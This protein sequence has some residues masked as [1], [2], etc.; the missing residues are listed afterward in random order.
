MTDLHALLGKAIPDP[1]RLRW[2]NGGAQLSLAIHCIFA[3]AKFR[4]LDNAGKRQRNPWLPPPE[5]ESRL[6]TEW[7][8]QY[9]RDD[10]A[11]GF[12]LHCSLHAATGRMF[13]HASEVLRDG[14]LVAHN[15]QVL[16]LQLQKYTVAGP[17]VD[18]SW[19]DIV[20]NESALVD[21]VRQYLIHPL[22]DQAT[23]APQDSSLPE[24]TS[25]GVSS[26]TGTGA[27]N[28]T[29]NGAGES[30]LAQLSTLLTR[31]RVSSGL[32]FAALAVTTGVLVHRWRGA[33]S[34]A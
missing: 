22:L 11:N 10:M 24:G 20:Q 31:H 14:S 1:R 17:T 23:L 15:I 33:G 18:R 6:P 9:T 16:G 30:T 8:F 28:E 4:V 32:V 2:T 25:G 12:R 7:V 13:A 26:Q 21:M 5:W 34:P 3:E 19:R 27:E 29:G